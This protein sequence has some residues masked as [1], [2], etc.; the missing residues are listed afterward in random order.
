[1]KWLISTRP[2]WERGWGEGRS[3]PGL[4]DESPL[5]R[6]CRATCSRKGSRNI[7]PLRGTLADA[8]RVSGY[9]DRK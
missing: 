1:M 5:I 2:L 6:P 7:E 8:L 3:V 4:R 9:E